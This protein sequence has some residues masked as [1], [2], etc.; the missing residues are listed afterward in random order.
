MMVK[1]GCFCGAIRYRI[2]CEPAQVAHCHCLHCRR[3]SGAPLV[4]WAVFDSSKFEYIKGT[5]GHYE[6]RPRVRRQFCEKCGT[7]LT[8][9]NLQNSAEIDVTVGSFDHPE[10]V[11]PQDHVWADRMLSWARLADGLPRYARDRTKKDD[12]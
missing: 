10:S 11:E 1:G 8:Y 7:Q 3:T 5:P 2:S 6:S 4:T 9:Q 12:K